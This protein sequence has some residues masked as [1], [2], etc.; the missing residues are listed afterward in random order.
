MLIIKRGV[1]GA[2]RSFYETY[3]QRVILGHEKI[4]FLVAVKFFSSSGVLRFLLTR[5]C[6][7]TYILKH[8]FYAETL[9]D[10]FAS[11]C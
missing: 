10:D 9:P 8:D 5:L 2:I 1:F 3:F 4:I 6:K 11:V 7:S